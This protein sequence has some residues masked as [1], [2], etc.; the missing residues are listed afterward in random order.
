MS[1]DGLLLVLWKKTWVQA[2]E[3]ADKHLDYGLQG[4]WFHTMWYLI[5]GPQ[6]KSKTRPWN[7]ES[8]EGT[9]A[10][11]CGAGRVRG[12][13]GNPYHADRNDCPPHLGLVAIKAT[14]PWR[15]VTRWGLPIWCGGGCLLSMV[16]S[17]VVGYWPCL[18]T[19]LPNVI[20]MSLASWDFF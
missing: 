18:H 9:G 16:F 13:M 11:W 8:R 19:A 17:E 10:L 3:V 12:D 5:V 7:K 15:G 6:A 14:S 20:C 1:F 2:I 4:P